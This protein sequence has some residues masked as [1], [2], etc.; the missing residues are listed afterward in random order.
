MP[1][2]RARLA[3]MMIQK[4]LKFN[5]VVSLQGARQT[6]KSFL[7]REIIVH[8]IKKSQFVTLDSKEERD[9]AQSSPSIFID[10]FENALP[11]II[12]EAQKAPNLFDEIKMRVDISTKPGRFILLG[13]TEFSREVLVKESLTGR[14]GRVRIFPMNFIEFM[15]NE[16]V[17]G[18]KKLQYPKRSNFLELLDRGGMPGIAF[19]RN[20]LERRAL[21]LDWINLVCYR[22]LS[23]FKKN[24][25]DSDLAIEIFRGVSTLEDPTLA[26]LTRFTKSTGKKVELHLK[27]LEQLFTIYRISPHLSSIGKKPIYLPFDCGL[28]WYFGASLRRKIQL[29]LL[30]ERL[31]DHHYHLR[32]DVQFSYYSSRTKNK[33]DLIEE[34]NLGTSAYQIIDSES[35]TSIDFAIMKA[36]SEKCPKAKCM[37]LAPVKNQ[38]SF[39]HHGVKIK[40]SPWEE[41]L[42]I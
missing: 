15:G 12:D 1:H 23:Q 29:K 37:I 35:F 38:T 42:D 11:L 4:K 9:I 8:D 41:L 3:L 30:N 16:Y 21:L 39:S 7:A 24:K 5:R 27:I 34:T 14:L 20:P 40:L 22:D 28:A 33:I 2:A 36:F 31:C 10:R 25:L 32:S 17:L 6:G 13:S 18:K 19:V 26:N